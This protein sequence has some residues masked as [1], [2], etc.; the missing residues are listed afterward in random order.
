MNVLLKIAIG[1][2]AAIFMLDWLMT[3]PG[4]P[5]EPT[6]PRWNGELDEPIWW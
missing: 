2:V 1:A 5:A 4:E 6:T 3:D